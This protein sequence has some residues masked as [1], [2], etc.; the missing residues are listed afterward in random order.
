MPQHNHEGRDCPPIP[1]RFW[2]KRFWHHRRL[3]E[4]LS[5]RLYPDDNGSEFYS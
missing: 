5:I 3:S 4:V 2:C 1:A